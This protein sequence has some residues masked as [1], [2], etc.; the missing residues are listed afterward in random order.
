[1]NELIK[2][3]IAV[4]MICILALVILIYAAWRNV[5]FRYEIKKQI[6]FAAGI[7]IIIIAAEIGTVVFENSIIE[8]HFFMCAANVVGFSLAPFVAIILAKAFS[9]EKGKITALLTIPA[10]INL[11]FVISSPWTGLIFTVSDYHYSRGPWFGVYI[12]AYLCSYAVLVLE[13]LKAMKRYQC[14]IKSTFIILL[15]FTLTG[16]L[17]QIILP[18]VYTSWMCITLS[19]ILYYAYFCELLETQDSLT[20][21]LNRNVY[22]QYVKNLNPNASGSVLVFDL[23]NFK[24]IN[25]LYGHQW[26]DYCLQTIGRII[27]DCFLHMGLCYRV[28][29]D[30]LCVICR[31]TDEQALKNALGL[32]HG[33]IDEIRK[34]SNTQNELPM[35]STG[36]AIFH[37]LERGYAAVMEDADTQMYGFKN[38]RRKHN[39]ETFPVN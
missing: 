19:L 14:H 8:S 12:V 34:T 15:A 26:G 35:V 32:F 28:G 36:Y 38:E 31:T 5:F 39:P 13:S 3:Y 17:V 30:E 24:L 7:T 25:D 9:M 27:K 33:K 37:S 10:W 18:D 22:D 16:T 21:L 29:G 20:G 6:I 1:M 2:N 4:D 23:D 11:A